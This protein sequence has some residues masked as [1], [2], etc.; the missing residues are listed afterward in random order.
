M[1][2]YFILT[3]HWQ[4][5]VRSQWVPAQLWQRWGERRDNG[6][7]TSVWEAGREPSTTILSVW[8]REGGRE[9]R[10]SMEGEIPED[11][12][13]LDL[14]QVGGG[15]DML[16]YLYMYEH[17]W[18]Y[19]RDTGWQ[20]IP[21]L[22]MLSLNGGYRLGIWL[23]TTSCSSKKHKHGNNT[24]TELVAVCMLCLYKSCD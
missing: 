13:L 2:H 19:I 3:F 23:V 24:T 17:T 20:K 7:G 10:V 18:K 6:S 12:Q 22:P 21:I 1:Q 5:A 11:Y 4:W 9:G 8:E 16:Q 15:H 14:H